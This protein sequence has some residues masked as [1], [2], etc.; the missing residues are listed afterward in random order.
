MKK[1]KIQRKLDEAKASNER[2]IKRLKGIEIDTFYLQ[3][4]CHSAE[5]QV[6]RLLVKIEDLETAL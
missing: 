1:T 3:I 6:V 4:Q 2:M 5:R